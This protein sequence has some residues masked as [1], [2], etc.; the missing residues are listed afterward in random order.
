MRPESD[1]IAILLRKQ[2]EEFDIL[3][4]AKPLYEKHGEEYW[5]MS[6]RNLGIRFV[7]VGNIF[8]G[9]FC[10][11]REERLVKPQIVRRPALLNVKKRQYSKKQ[12]NNALASKS[13]RMKKRRLRKRLNELRPHVVNRQLGGRLVSLLD[14]GIIERSPQRPSSTT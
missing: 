9:L 11:V 1:E 13:M 4:K 3:Q 10:P 14:V 6:L 8:S 7:T 5:M 12:R 2:L